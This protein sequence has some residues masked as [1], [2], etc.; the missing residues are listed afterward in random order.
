MFGALFQSQPGS[1]DLVLLALRFTLGAVVVAHGAQKLLGWFGGYGFK[2]TMDYFTKTLGFPALL[3][4]L[5][6]VAEFFG[7]LSLVA[8]LFTRVAALGVGIVLLTAAY[9]VHRRNG[10]FMN[11]FGNQ[12]GE[13]V[14]YFVLAAAIVLVLLV[15]GGGTWSLDHA[16]AALAS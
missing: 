15:A 10:F 8:G 14:E 16:L 3:G 13:G 6:I 5:A 7:S 4:F 12:E 1:F 2:G 9:T 11:W